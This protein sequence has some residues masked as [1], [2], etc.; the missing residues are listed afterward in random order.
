MFWENF[1]FEQINGVCC[2]NNFWEHFNFEQI[3]G[4]CCLSGAGNQNKLR[5]KPRLP[6]APPDKETENW[7]HCLKTQK[8]II[9]SSDIFKIIF[10][11][12]DLLWIFCQVGFQ[13]VI[14]GEM[15]VS[16]KKDEVFRKTV[17]PWVSEWVSDEGLFQEIET[18]C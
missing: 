1:K 4:V 18:S 5:H 14:M 2:Q 11:F 13:L 7:I 9:K 6:A 10:T 16:R 3:N 17:N 12:L 8:K 15:T